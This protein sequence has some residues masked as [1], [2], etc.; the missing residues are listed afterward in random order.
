MPFMQPEQEV[1]PRPMGA[2]IAVA[3]QGPIAWPPSSP[4]PL[5]ASQ[6]P[7]S[8][9]DIAFQQQQQQPQMQQQPQQQ[10]LPVQMAGQQFM[11]PA[12]PVAAQPVQAMQPMQQMQPQPVYGAFAPAGG[13]VFA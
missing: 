9:A 6:Q 2:G 13:A 5:A 4:P 12:W 8:F 10:P 1:D 7:R 11:Q 3:S